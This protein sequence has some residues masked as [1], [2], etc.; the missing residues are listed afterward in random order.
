MKKITFLVLF[1]LFSAHLL[2]GQTPQT[3]DGNLTRS[4]IST[5]DIKFWV[6]SGNDSVVLIINWCDPGIAFAWGYCFTDSVNVATMMADIVAADPN[7]DYRTQIS[8]INDLIYNDGTYDLSDPESWM[9]DVNGVTASSGIIDQ[10]IYN[11]DTVEFGGYIC[12][13]WNYPVYPALP[14]QTVCDVPANPEVEIDNDIVTLSWDGTA[15]EYLIHYSSGTLIDTVISV[16]TDTYIIED[17]VFYVDYSWNIRAVCSEGDTSDM[18]TG[19]TF[20][21]ELPE[22]VTIPAEDILFWIGTGTNQAIFTVNWCDPEIAFAWGYRF[23]DSV[24]LSR[25]MDDIASTDARIEFTTGSWSIDEITYQD[26][27]YDLSLTGDYW[28]ININGKGA[29]KGYSQLYIKNNDFI[30]LG[31]VA[32]AQDDGQFNFTWTTEITPVS[33]PAT[34]GIPSH[35]SDISLNLYPNPANN[36][37]R[38]EIEGNQQS[39][40]MSI[41]DVNG[42][43]MSQ[44]TL[45]SSDNS[46]SISV[47][48][49]AK[50]IY[51]LR[52][53][54]SQDSQTTKLIVY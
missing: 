54:N 33:V 43:I 10:K 51:F 45:Y 27:E 53:Q 34:T 17:A 32:C 2:S 20:R 44:Q 25:I 24:L 3:P 14:L 16:N 37:I 38:L 41:L 29:E 48:H 7:L 13:P 19:E 6:G 18:A 8:Y 5:S 30:K 47:S 1:L 23:N 11:Y 52:V 31:D 9:Y 36:Y 42:K 21:L 50:G 39:Y 26:H 46:H 12:K 40:E 28:W 49:L 15:D 22:D 35:Q 4:S